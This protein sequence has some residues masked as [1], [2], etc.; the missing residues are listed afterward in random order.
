MVGGTI[1]SMKVATR[2]RPSP[3]AKKLPGKLN[4]VESTVKR[5]KKVFFVEIL[6]HKYRFYL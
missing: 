6:L 3:I 5:K 4:Q 2:G 1:F